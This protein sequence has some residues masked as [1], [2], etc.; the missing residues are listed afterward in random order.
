M[1]Q[2]MVIVALSTMLWFVI[3]RFKG[4]WADLSWGW[5][6]TTMIAA[7]GGAGLVFS[8]NLDIVHALGLA[9]EPGFVGQIMTVIALM[10]G[11]SAV[12]EIIDGVGRNKIQGE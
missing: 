1:N 7:V 2:L 12:S 6:L 11:S 4:F 10:S 3:D 8:Y 9:S 5:L